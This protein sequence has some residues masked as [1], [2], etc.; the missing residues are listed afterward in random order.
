M[1]SNGLTALNLAIPVYSFIHGTGLMLGMRGATRYSMLKGQ[2]R[3]DEKNRVFTHIMCMVCGFGILFFATSLLGD[4]TITRLLGADEAVYSMCNTY[5]KILLLFAPEKGAKIASFIAKIILLLYNMETIEF[6]IGGHV[7]AL[8]EAQKQEWEK[9]LRELELISEE[10]AIEEHTA[11]SYWWLASQ[12]RGNFFFTKEKFIFVSGFGFDNFA[13][14][15]SDIR[16]IKKSV[17]GPFI[18]T[19]TVT[20]FVPEKG[21]EKRYKCAVWKRQKWIDLLC[22]KSGIN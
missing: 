5:L 22:K 3:E 16:A 9:T 7:M 10:D 13:I 15:Y 21:K 14:K 11:G 12:T 1:G 4:G 6:C 19:I 17:V 18:P 8:S 2:G 20:A